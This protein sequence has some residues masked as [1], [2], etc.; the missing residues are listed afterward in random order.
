[1]KKIYASL[2]QSEDINSKITRIEPITYGD[3]LFYGW[4]KTFYKTVDNPNP[5]SEKDKIIQVVDTSN[6][7]EYD[8]LTQSLIDIE[9]EKKNGLKLLIDNTKV[10]NQLTESQKQ[11]MNMLIDNTNLKQQNMDLQK[12][13]MNMLVQIT[14]LQKGAN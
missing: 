5:K 14:K 9:N 1:M 11:Q 10:K 13:Q 12:S 6:P 2:P 4:Q 7:V 3:K 8:N